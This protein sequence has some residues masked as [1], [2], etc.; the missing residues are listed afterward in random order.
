MWAIN[1]EATW[2]NLRWPFWKQLVVVKLL[3]KGTS[4]LTLELLA[5][6]HDIVAGDLLG[7]PNYLEA[8]INWSARLRPSPGGKTFLFLSIPRESPF[9]PLLTRRWDTLRPIRPFEAASALSANHPSKASTWA[10]QQR[11]RLNVAEAPTAV[12]GPASRQSLVDS[13]EQREVACASGWPSGVLPRRL[14]ST[15]RNFDR[16]TTHLVL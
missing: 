6:I 10:T 4:R 3:G 13:G 12:R 16:C 5:K 7:L 8:L 1:S 2:E 11:Q 9:G 15:F 14:H